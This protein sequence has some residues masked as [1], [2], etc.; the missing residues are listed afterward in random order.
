MKGCV[1]MKC[2][3]CFHA[4]PALEKA[5]VRSNIA[6]HRNDYF[7]V[8][9]CAACRSLSCEPVP[10]YAPYYS[11][12]ALRHMARGRLVDEWYGNILE[13]L[14]RAGLEKQD[15]ILDFGC[16]HGLLI[17]YLR[18]QGYTR[19]NGYD[20]YTPEF[21][22][23]E[24]LA[25]V[26]DLVLCID[27]I[28][29]DPEPRALLKTLSDRV[30]PGGL[31][32]IGTPDAEFIDLSQPEK[33]IHYLHLSCHVHVLTSPVLDRM[34]CEEL[35]LRRVASWDHW[36]MDSWIPGASPAFFER[37]MRVHGN[38]M[39]SAFEQPRLTTFLSHPSLI[40]FL[41]FGWLHSRDRR[42]Y[43]MTIYQRPVESAEV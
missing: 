19:V 36:F 23:Q 29:H 14:Q 11:G 16:G 30:K 37:F 17:S 4:G 15:T 2:H 34:V 42:D 38:D 13:R 12:Y 6:R 1:L 35:G 9:R 28:E 27:V 20:P 25:A 18:D 40:Y 31:L 8:E 43:I 24:S 39:E 3:L 41:F 26:Y 32:C 21:A 33:Y 22:G 5:R 10:D 7:E